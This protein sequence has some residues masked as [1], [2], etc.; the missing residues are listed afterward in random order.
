MN[1]FK[2]IEL[3]I[4]AVLFSSR[5][6]LAPFFLALIV[7]LVA[8]LTKAF[9]HTYHLFEHILAASETTV[10]LDLLSLI[11]LTFTGALVVLVIFS[12]YENF[13]SRIDHADEPDGE[14]PMPPARRHGRNGCAKSTSTVSS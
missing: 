11:D 12:G 14:P 9:Q 5:W 3:T 1:F 7:S 13:V 10:V 6:L 2:R 4:E 8:L